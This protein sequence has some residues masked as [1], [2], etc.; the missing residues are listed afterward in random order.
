V[1][2]LELD[3]FP[4]HE[5]RTD[6]RT[7]WRDGVLDVDLDELLGLVRQDNRIDWASVDVARPGDSTRIVNVYDVWQ[8]MVK[9]EGPGQ[10]YPVVSGRASDPV[11]QGRTQR[12][13]GVCVV[14]CSNSAI[15]RG[16]PLHPEDWTANIRRRNFYDMSGPRANRPWAKQVAVCVTMERTP[17]VSDEDWEDARRAACLRVSDR[18]AETAVGQTAPERELFDTTKRTSGLPG[19][20]LVP[21]LV[22]R[23]SFRGP[24]TTIG[25]AVYG[26]ARQSAPWLLHPTEVMDGAMTRQITWYQVNNP[27]VY[28][29]ARGHGRDW[30]F[31]G[32]LHQKTNW[33][34]MPEKE[35]IAHR[36]GELARTLGADGAIVTLDIRGARFVETILTCQALERA[37]VKTV[38]MATEETSEGGL[39]PPLLLSVP[40]LVSVV[41]CGDGGVAGPFPAVERVLGAR[42][43]NPEDFA[44][45]PGIKGGYGSG[46]TWDDYYGYDRYSGVDF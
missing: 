46:D 41:S 1:Y 34:S 15:L 26:L 17:E 10:T 2:R 22:S 23:E 3:S 16:R 9:V 19:Y 11:G 24:R 13:D 27:S 21:M 6:G 32:V 45:H 28:H 7:A 43:T 30:N 5:V 14:E 36:V 25:P 39:A 20:V 8:P 38:F 37:G 33:T 31:L 12:L 18:L 29:L 42:H 44:E 40:E 4:V 35:V